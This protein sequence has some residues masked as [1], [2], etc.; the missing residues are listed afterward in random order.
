MIDQIPVNN[1]QDLVVNIQS[2]W[3]KSYDLSIKRE[4]IIQIYSYR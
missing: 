2:H 4:N 3:L 1:I